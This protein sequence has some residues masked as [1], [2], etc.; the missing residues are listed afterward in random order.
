MNTFKVSQN[1]HDYDCKTYTKE[2][3]DHGYRPICILEHLQKRC[4]AAIEQLRS[5]PYG[6][7]CRRSATQSTSTV[8]GLLAIGPSCEHRRRLGPRYVIQDGRDEVAAQ[9]FPCAIQKHC[10][11]EGQYGGHRTRQA[12]L[13]VPRN[14][15]GDEG[16]VGD[17]PVNGRVSYLYI[18]PTIRRAAP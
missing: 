4:I 17:S 18:P 7:R 14:P 12:A 13:A 15:K 1:H 8:S 3:V 6:P 5:V 2:C 16:E 11:E 10:G 9:D